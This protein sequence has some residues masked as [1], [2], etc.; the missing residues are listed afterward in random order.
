MLELSNVPPLPTRQHAELAGGAGVFEEVLEV[1]LPDLCDTVDAAV[2]VAVVDGRLV[3]DIDEARVEVVNEA[4][5][6]PWFKDPTG[7]PLLLSPIV[8]G[9]LVPGE[10][11]FDI[12]VEIVEVAAE[13]DGGR[14]FTPY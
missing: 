3:L 2:L 14:Q 9:L 11:T 4:E 1:V 6:A 7:R 10:A 13:E 8:L 5:E 12:L